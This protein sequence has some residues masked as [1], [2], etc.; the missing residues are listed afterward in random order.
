MR[1]ARKGTVNELGT[2]D[3]DEKRFGLRSDITQLQEALRPRF[4]EA[5]AER[6]IEKLCKEHRFIHK[7]VGAGLSKLDSNRPGRLATALR[8]E[9]VDVVTS[10][11]GL[12]YTGSTRNLRL[13]DRAGSVGPTTL[14]ESADTL[15]CEEDC[16][17]LQSF[18]T[19]PMNVSLNVLNFVDDAKMRALKAPGLINQELFD[20]LRAE[21]AEGI[22]QEML[23]MPCAFQNDVPNY[24][25][26]TQSRID[27]TKL[28][29][30]L[31]GLQVELCDLAVTADEFNLL[32]YEAFVLPEGRDELFDANEPGCVR[33]FEATIELTDTTPW[34][35]RLRPM[36]QEDKLHFEV[37]LNRYLSQGLV[38]KAMNAT[39]S[40]IAMLVKKP[41]GRHQLAF[42]YRELNKRC[43]A[44]LWPLPLLGDCLDSMGLATFLSSIDVNGAYHSIPVAEASRNYL[45]FLCP[46]G[47]FRWTRLPYGYKNSGPIFCQQIAEALMGLIYAIISLYA[48]DGKIFGGSTV[49]MHVKCIS[50]CFNRLHK[51]GFRLSLDKCKFFRREMD[52]LGFTAVVGGTKPTQQNVKKL[53]AICI[54][55]V[56]DI[57]GFIGLSNYYRRYCKGYSQIIAPLLPYLRKDARLPAVLP[58][59]IEVAVNEIKGVLSAFPVLRNPDFKRQFLLETDGSKHGFGAVLKQLYDGVELVCAYA[60][61]HV[62]KCQLK[63]S[64]DMLELVAAVWGM[65]HFRHYLRRPFILKTDNCIL[66]W[67]R[68]KT[69]D[70][71]KPSFIKWILEVQEYDF[72]VQH[73]PGKQL[74]AGDLMSRAGAR[75][76]EVDPLLAKLE[77]SKYFKTELKLKR[78]LDREVKHTE[79]PTELDRSVWMREQAADPRLVRMLASKVNQRCFELVDGLWHHKRMW[80]K[81]GSGDVAKLRVVVPASLRHSLMVI[82][83]SLLGHRGV[84]PLVKYLTRLLYFPGVWTYA[85]AWIGSCSDCKRR[86]LSRIRQPWVGSVKHITTPWYFVA[87]DFVLGELPESVEGYK[88]CLTV[89]CV[90]TRYPFAL[91][92]RTKKPDEI[93]TALFTGV[94]SIFGFPVVV[95]SD[96]DS[97]LIDQALELVFRRFNVKRSYTLWSHP[98]SN[99]HLERWHRYFN[100]TMAIILPRYS[101][102]PEMVPVALFAYRGM[103]QETSG[104]SPHFLNFG[105]DALMPLEVSWCTGVPDDILNPNDLAAASKTYAD[106]LISRL[107]GAFHFVRRAQWLA[108]KRNKDR[109]APNAPDGGKRKR[110]VEVIRFR[111]GDVV[112]L[113]EESSVHNKVGKMRELTPDPLDFVPMKWRFR[114]TGPHLVLRT[115]GERAYVIQ[116]SDRHEE[117]IV[118][119]DDLRPHHPFSDEVFDTAQEWAYVTPKDL[120]PPLGYNS[121]FPKG[122]STQHPAVG[123]LCLAHVPLFA[124]EDFVIL[125]YLGGDDYQWYSST[126]AGGRLDNDWNSFEVLERTTWLPGWLLEPEFQRVQYVYDQP[127]GSRPWTCTSEELPYGLMLWGFELTSS[128]KIRKPMMAWVQQYC[129]PG[130]ATVVR[131]GGVS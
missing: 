112:Y 56:K 121:E 9:V 99:G 19:C 23:Q 101:D 98:Q 11:G 72:E 38:E 120:P 104:Y 102:W 12:N 34:Y 53:L 17:G 20:A 110:D 6:T 94:F 126:F 5:T 74:V 8:D 28:P 30:H 73:V 82:T 125:K 130:N 14:N 95:H 70:A 87:I 129:R 96:H 1:R 43:V 36:A 107:Q 26:E 75:D 118:H 109:L 113:H 2:S 22:V 80:R 93:A 7:G 41:S 106:R 18:N 89:M 42:D 51:K 58:K 83:H 114:W 65:K 103:A 62:L 21:F 24:F 37:V 122:A 79:V 35:A 47:I 46:Y 111:A 71:T 25:D 44:C 29:E 91:P 52:H 40:A 100:E 131:H 115:E 128:S 39:N 4:D 27:V 127:V 97:T 86:K 16:S 64:S 68:R 49:Q 59:D 124:P 13:L 50:L 54:K 78:A 76:S 69:V 108:S 88:Y 105:K 61:S 3:D 48:D 119:V 31:R 84:K 33:D 123:D 60:S 116:H 55:K 45:A 90:F 67:L 92:L 57:R 15:V 117:L 66:K 10:S 85:R 63:Y 81:R 77:S 32:I